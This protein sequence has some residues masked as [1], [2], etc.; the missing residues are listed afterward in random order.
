[1]SHPSCSRALPEELHQ[2]EGSALSPSLRETVRL[3]ESDRFACLTDADVHEIANYRSVELDEQVFFDR[4]FTPG[5]EA[6]AT[7]AFARRLGRET[8]LRDLRLLGV[9][10]GWRSD[11][12]SS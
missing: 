8:V 2:F 6:A 3:L 5:K 10:L 12:D 4:A 7:L 1:M 11:R 9:T